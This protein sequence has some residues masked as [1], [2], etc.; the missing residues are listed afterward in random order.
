MTKPAGRCLR[1]ALA[2]ACAPLV[3]GADMG[4]PAP[5]QRCVAGFY[6]GDGFEIAA[7]LE[8]RPDHRFRYGLSYGAIDEQA[9]GRW[10]FG[11]GGVL[12][13]SDPITPPRFVLVGEAAGADGRFHIA[14]DVPE[15][16]SRQFF[17]V[18][19]RFSDGRASQRQLGEEGLD[20]DLAAGQRPVSLTL[21]LP[22]YDLESE[23]F[24]LAPGAG[25]DAGG[26][27]R[28]RF[29]PNDL[30]R[31]AFAETRLPYQGEDLLLDRHAR[32]IAFRRV[33]SD[34]D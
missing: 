26:A 34:C 12:L 3:L 14:L 21:L 10:D 17:A 32:Q 16:L 7:G 25:P 28:F 20:L 31:V 18:L 24:P 15:G 5:V 22:I 9:S 2:L 8:L 19:V 27:V 30:G 13:T 4:P 11:K 23:T 33:R 6:D 1:A 29:D